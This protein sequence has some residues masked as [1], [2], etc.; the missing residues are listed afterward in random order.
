MFLH[1]SFFQELD[2]AADE[3]QEASILLPSGYN[4]RLEVQ[5]ALT[6]VSAS[7]RKAKG[8]PADT[9]A[10]EEDMIPDSERYPLLEIPNSELTTEQVKYYS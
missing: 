6:K 1:S 5:A 10:V 2:D 3:K 8:Q 9:K 4:S 7:L